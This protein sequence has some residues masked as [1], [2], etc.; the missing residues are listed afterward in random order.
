[1]WLRKGGESEGVRAKETRRGGFE[2]DLTIA[3]LRC[4]PNERKSPVRSLEVR[5][6]I[7]VGCDEPMM[8]LEDGLLEWNIYRVAVLEEVIVYVEGVERARKST[9][10]QA[11]WPSLSCSPDLTELARSPYSSQ[12]RPTGGT[13]E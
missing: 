6:P 7:L 2:E 12:P 3:F 5:A 1:M 4:S 13:H 11:E 10:R 8:K 9:T